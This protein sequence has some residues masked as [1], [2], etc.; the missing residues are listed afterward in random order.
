MKN[1]LIQAVCTF[2]GALAWIAAGM[3][4]AAFLFWRVFEA[5]LVPAL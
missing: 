2:T 5:L 4:F 3:W 1:E